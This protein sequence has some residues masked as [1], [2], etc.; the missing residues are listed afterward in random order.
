MHCVKSVRTRSYS[1]PYFPAFQLNAEIHYVNLHIQSEGGKIRTR[2]TPNTDT[3]HP[4]LVIAEHSK[5]KI[6]SENSVT[7]LRKRLWAKSTIYF[8]RFLACMPPAEKT[9]L[10]EKCQIFSNFLIG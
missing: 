4:V 7:V 5:H 1:G 2:K 6:F 9:Y 3:F 10:A 8:V